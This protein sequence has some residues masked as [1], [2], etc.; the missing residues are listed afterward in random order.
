M[1]LAEVTG[2]TRIMTVNGGIRLTLAPTV[3]AELEATVINGGVS[4]QEGF[5]LSGDERNRQR[6][7]GRLGNGGPRLLVQT[8]NGG[9]RVQSRA[10]PAS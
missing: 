9:V 7:A 6:V 8:T 4:V 10:V 2:D 1:D 5:P 3:N